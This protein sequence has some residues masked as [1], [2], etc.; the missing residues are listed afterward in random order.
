M[1][2]TPRRVAQLIF[3]TSTLG[4]AAVA[5]AGLKDKPPDGVTLAGTRWQIDPHH[6]DD[7]GA[8]IDDAHRAMQDR[9]ARDRGSMSRGVPGGRDGPWGGDETSGGTWGGGLP[10]RAS[11]PGGWTQRKGDG[12]TDIDPT[13]G[14]QS[15][16]IQ[17]GSRPRNEF[18][19]TLG[20][21]PQEL[22]FLGAH[23]HVKVT[24]DGLE[25]DCEAGIR[26]PLSDSYGD[27]EI[28]CGWSGRAWVV[29]TTRGKLFTRTDRYEL[30]KDGKTLRYVTTARGKAM[31]D[32]RI[33]RTYTVAPSG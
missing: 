26:A 5:S 11:R 7:P 15:A 31:P 12:S 14:T 1:I 33:S 18:L 9:T 28:N 32:I 16:S 2:R 13:G 24:A 30:S 17:W 8:V 3:L 6:S 20:K 10:D 25:T 21:N 23:Q 4:L 22:T 29:E 19:D 27:G